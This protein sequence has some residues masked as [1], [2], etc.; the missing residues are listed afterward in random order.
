M[1]ILKQVQSVAIKILQ[2]DPKLELEKNFKL[3]KQIIDN[4]EKRI[5]I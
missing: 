2:E 4:F 1:E 5:E 3:K